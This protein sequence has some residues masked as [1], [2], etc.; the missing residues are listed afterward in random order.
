MKG[1]AGFDPHPDKYLLL[2][3]EKGPCQKVKYGLKFAIFVY[4]DE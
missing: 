2:P 1:T 3:I 4:K